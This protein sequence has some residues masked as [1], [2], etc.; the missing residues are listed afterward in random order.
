MNK[1]VTQ[2]KPPSPEPTPLAASSACRD[3]FRLPPEQTGL[4]PDQAEVV[5]LSSDSS[6]SEFNTSLNH[7]KLQC[8]APPKSMKKSNKK[9][10][11]AELFG[12]LNDEETPNSMDTKRELIVELFGYI[13]DDDTP[14]PMSTKSCKLETS[15][16]KKI[17]RKRKSTESEEVDEWWKQP[18]T[19]TP[20]NDQHKP[21]EKSCLSQLLKF[22][23]RKRMLPS[24]PRARLLSC[25]QNHFHKFVGAVKRKKK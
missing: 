21:F 15:S 3:S 6:D 20:S 23:P 14:K 2:I 13:S 16:R 4:K 12:T 8:S 19:G 9:Q 10:L 22:Q 18:I 11:M 7:M 25:K 24:V 5:V 17:T 1:P